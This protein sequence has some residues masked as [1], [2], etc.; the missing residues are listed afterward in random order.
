MERAQFNRGGCRIK[1][2]QR[3]C[4]HLDCKLLSAQLSEL[5]ADFL[6]G[7]KLKRRLKG[8][9]GRE[10]CGLQRARLFVFFKSDVDKNRRRLKMGKVVE[11]FIEV[12]CLLMLHK[13]AGDIRQIHIS[14]PTLSPARVVAFGACA[15]VQP[16][17]DTLRQQVGVS[18]EVAF[19]GA[20][21]TTDPV[22]F[23]VRALPG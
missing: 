22:G 21:V 11:I 5:G 10:P 20:E 23:A 16:E 15:T 7:I 3:L 9:G 2:R 13:D 8:F 6:A 1:E 19:E 18:R 4:L 14:G 12:G 17:H